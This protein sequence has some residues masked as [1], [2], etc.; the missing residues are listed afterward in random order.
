MNRNP[1]NAQRG[2]TMWGWMLIVVVAGFFLTLAAKLG[3]VY[4]KNFTVQSTIKALQ[5]EPELSTKSQVEVR[6][7]VQRKFDV[8][9]I[10]GIE[11]TC[12]DKR[13]DCLKITKTAEIMTINANYEVRVHMMGN[14]DAMVVF[15]NNTVEL[16]IKSGR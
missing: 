13:V 2:F 12:H 9:R 8:N 7:A 14:V 5:N 3:P 1:R 11:A 15:N 16:P 4:I 10:E 6:R